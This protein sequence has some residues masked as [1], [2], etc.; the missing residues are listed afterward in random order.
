MKQ[1]AAFQVAKMVIG[2]EVVRAHFR[3]YPVGAD[4]ASGFLA[5]L[6][7]NHHQ[8]CLVGRDGLAESG[9]PDDTINSL[10]DGLFGIAAFTH[11]ALGLL[12]DFGEDGGKID[13]H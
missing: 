2:G 1:M 7:D 13:H 3:A 11:E 6:G 9:A 10:A 12:A 8:A 5:Y 4:R